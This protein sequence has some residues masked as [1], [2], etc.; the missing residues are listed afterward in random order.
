MTN[1]RYNTCCCWVDGRAEVSPRFASHCWDCGRPR[2][3]H[4]DQTPIWATAI[5]SDG[6]K[7]EKEERT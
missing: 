5:R 7:S 6:K 3:E 4:G 1:H 2:E